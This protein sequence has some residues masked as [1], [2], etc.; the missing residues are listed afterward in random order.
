[1][2]AQGTGS[3]AFYLVCATVGLVILGMAANEWRRL[4]SAHYQR[5]TVAAGVLLLGR[6]VGLL[7]LPT[8]WSSDMGCQ[9]WV[10]E[11]LTLTGFMWAYLF[12]TFT[13]RR[14]A[15]LFVVAALTMVLGLL[16]PCLLIR[17]GWLLPPLP[18]A[19]WPM[20]LLLLS[21][22]GLLQW[23]RHRQRF[24]LWLGSAFLVSSV[25]AGFALLGFQQSALLAH[26][27]ALP[28]FAIETYRAILVDLSSYGLEL[29][30]LGK[31]A[32]QQTQDLALLLEVSQAIAASLDLT[33]VLERVS[34]AMA[35]AVNADWAYVLLRVDDHPEELIVAARYSWWGQRWTQDSQLQ[36]QLTIRLAD[37]SLLRHAIV[38]RRQVSANLPTD[39]EQFRRLHDLQARPQ[40][41]PTL[42]QPIF[43]QNRSL[44]AMLLGHVG[45]RNTFSEAD[46]KLCQALV[47][48]VA[49]AI[50]NARLFQSLEDQAHQLAE[51][52]RVREQEAVQCQA[53]LE[54]IADGVA[55]TNQ[56]GEVILV[57]AAAER[58]LALPRQE[59]IGQTINRRYPGL[60]LTD[61]EGTDDQAV[62]AWG[63]RAVKRSLAPVRMPD[64]AV[65]GYVAVFRDV[66]HEQQAQQ[67]T[68]GF[69]ATVSHK[70]QTPLT[71]I[72]GYIELLL[73]GAAGTVPPQQYRLLDIVHSDT[74]QMISLVNNLIV[75][76]EMA[77]EE[78][79]IDP[80]PVDMRNVITE[81]VEAIGSRA[82]ERQ[83]DLQV[84]LPRD[85]KPAKGDPEQL[86]QI[87]DNL[88]DNSVRYTPPGGSITVWAAEAH[89]AEETASPR[90]YLVIGVR[91]TGVGIPPEEHDRIFEKFYRVDSPLLVEAS[92]TGMGLAI[93]KS[94]V[95]AHGGRIWVES[96]SEAGSTFS[97]TIPSLED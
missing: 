96:D 21:G 86:R 41:G 63:S 1:V 6:M 39:Y 17:L 28:L 53:I 52:L 3:T 59:L 51:L 20:V 69:V 25:G 62:L 26:L 87:M 11:G 79:E 48:Q 64:G 19:V 55:T 68:S 16:I 60:T 30:V 2:L 18:S 49:A 70:L 4:G 42:V 40:S 24:S 73:H 36:R 57:N 34:E 5:I 92:G 23:I 88:L 91:D 78:I 65:L 74:E 76:S 61:E 37:F 56:A 97:F 29:Q 31:Q 38:R 12:D 66:T 82:A 22:V 9:E 46:G 45:S 85:L 35:R 80:W 90:H 83:L 15:S 54:S 43:R 81:A 84:N 44:G 13:T 58:I 67:A 77:Q 27:G 95:E 7:V 14:R 89:L 72:K 71:S 93:V 50:D 8:D 33:V 47:A 94:L 75:V 32:L 10:L